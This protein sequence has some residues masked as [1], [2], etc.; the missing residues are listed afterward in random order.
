M[1]LA[2]WPVAAT[3]DHQVPD[4][5]TPGCDAYA[6]IHSRAAESVPINRPVVLTT[7]PRSGELS[8]SRSNGVNPLARSHSMDVKFS[9]ALV[10]LALLGLAQGRRRGHP[11]PCHP[12]SPYD[13]AAARVSIT[14]LTRFPPCGSERAL[15]LLA[16]QSWS[17]LGPRSAS[18]GRALLDGAPTPSPSSAEQPCSTEALGDVSNLLTLIK[19]CALGPLRGRSPE[20][21][22]PRL[23]A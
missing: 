7:R 10:V 16:S 21:C 9:A 1:A 15:L 19:G 13:A 11:R 4:L 14:S 17:T 20:H 23:P 6:P 8:R 18:A 3:P 5:V 12:S 2:T 22:P